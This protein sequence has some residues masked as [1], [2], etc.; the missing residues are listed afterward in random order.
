MNNHFLLFASISYRNRKIFFSNIPLS[1]V[2]YKKSDHSLE[3]TRVMAS[4]TNYESLMLLMFAQFT[5][6]LVDEIR[7]YLLRL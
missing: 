1:Q 5:G 3:M 6:A 2:Q 7:F 4:V